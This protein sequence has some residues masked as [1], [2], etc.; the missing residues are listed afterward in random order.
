MPQSSNSSPP[1]SETIE[2]VMNWL[3][4]ET[5]LHP[6]AFMSDCCKALS[7]GIK[8]AFKLCRSPPKHYLCVVH[9]MKAAR[10]KGAKRVSAALI[11]P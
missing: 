3:R 7:K 6:A 11:N 1:H 8:Q 10:R 4:K 5:G 9:V 2:Y